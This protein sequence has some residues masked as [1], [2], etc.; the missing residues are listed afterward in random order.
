MFPSTRFR[1]TPCKNEIP[2]YGN[3]LALVL[4]HG[5][6]V[7]ITLRTYYDRAPIA[8]LAAPDLGLSVSEVT[9]PL[10]KDYVREF[11]NVLSSKVRANLMKDGIPA[12]ASLPVTGRGI[13]E[14]FFGPPKGLPESDGSISEFTWDNGSFVL[15]IRTEIKTGRGQQILRALQSPSQEDQP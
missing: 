13:D 6:D 10:V 11:A 2:I 4:I 15:S 14:L 3:W 1:C 9:D 7:K 8:E 5:P 12:V